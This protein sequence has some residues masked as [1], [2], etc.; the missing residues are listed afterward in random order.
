[1]NR[2]STHDIKTLVAETFSW[3]YDQ[4]TKDTGPGDVPRWDSLGHIQL[5]E[6]LVSRFDVEIPIDEAVE[7]RSIGALAGILE[8]TRR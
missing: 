1:M 4:L 7:A 6:A 8:R 2:D 5:L 3:P